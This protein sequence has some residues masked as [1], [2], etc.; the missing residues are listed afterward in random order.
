MVESFAKYLVAQPF[1]YNKI[2]TFD[3]IKQ[4]FKEL[5][6]S[7]PSENQLKILENKSS[8]SLV[9]PNYV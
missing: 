2:P 9:V 6:E 4:R 8:S 3:D 1:L 7:P 5:Y